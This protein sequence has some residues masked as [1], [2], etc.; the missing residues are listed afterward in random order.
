MTSQIK[1]AIIGAGAIVEEAHLSHL[2]NRDDVIVKAIVDINLERCQYLSDT[3]QIPHYFETV[4]ELIDQ[5]DV[6]GVMICTP[7][8]THIPIAIQCAKHGIHIFLE[9]PIGVNLEEVEEYIEVAKAHHVH[10]MIGMTHRF[11]DDVATL[12]SYIDHGELGDIHYVKAKM[13]R[14]RGTPLGWFTNYSLAGGGALLDIGVHTLDLAWTL[15]GEPNVQSITGKA[16]NTMGKYGV[17]QT[18]GWK[19][20]NQ[21]L[22]G[23]EVFDVDDFVTSWIR[24]DNG[25]VL[26]LEVAWASNGDEGSGMK[27]D[28]FGDRGGATLSPLT[29][30]KEEFGTLVETKPVVQAKDPFKYEL[31]HFIECLKNGEQ[32]LVNEQHG[33]DILRM[34][35]GIYESSKQNREIVF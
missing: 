34:L 3:Y 19:S 26:S 5:V 30:Y 20:T 33:Y 29:V 28:L 24:F 13:F 8:S 18:P 31:N 6:D 7:N 23:T 27:I 14:R 10:T 9:K 17:N 21:T 4:D 2:L 11:R 16:L 12:K 25:T 35:V 1:L 15:I 32:P 22:N